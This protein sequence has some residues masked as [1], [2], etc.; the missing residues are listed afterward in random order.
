MA[1]FPFTVRATDS[2]GSYADR[3]FSITVRNSRVE[4]FMLLNATDAYTSPDATSWTKR[5]GQGGTMCAYGNGFWL[6]VLT[7]QT[8]QFGSFS[9][10]SIRK[11]TDGINYQFSPGT[12]LTF[13]KSDGTPWSTNLNLFF[14]MGTPTSGYKLTFWNGKFWFLSPGN[15]LTSAVIAN[16]MLLWS[17]PDGLTWTSTVL[18]TSTSAT[19]AISMNSVGNIFSVSVSDGVMMVPNYALGG[20]TF[21][22]GWVTSDGVNFTQLKNSASSAATNQYSH[23]LTRINGL[24]LSMYNQVTGTGTSSYNIYQ[25]S[26]DGLNWTT[27]PLPTTPSGSNYSG[28]FFYMNGLVYSFYSSTVANQPASFLYSSDAINWT[29]GQFQSSTNATGSFP[30]SVVAKNGLLVAA[31]QK[32]MATDLPN[33][34]PGTPT[35]GIR[36]SVDGLT[37]TSV[38]LPGLPTDLVSDLAAMS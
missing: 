7:N 29:I 3:Q 14:G 24:Y 38:S 6:T 17:S 1:V 33:S 8:N 28:P 5:T 18:N 22:M 35:N 13:L 20:T 9:G 21:C 32:Q 12:S 15:T 27:A 11:S 16:T 26:T 4:R 30:Y 2:E 19:N 23:S 25:F 31:C 37:F 34:S 36:V 10:I